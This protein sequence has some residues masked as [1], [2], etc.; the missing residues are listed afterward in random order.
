MMIRKTNDDENQNL[1]T[2][3]GLAQPVFAPTTTLFRMPLPAQSIRLC[4]SVPLMNVSTS[5]IQST[6]WF[7]VFYLYSSRK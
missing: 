2:Q 1:V 3:K 6:Y 5:N 4:S 7:E